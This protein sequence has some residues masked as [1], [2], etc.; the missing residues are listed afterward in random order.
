MSE[1]NTARKQGEKSAS[2]AE[3]FTSRQRVI[4]AIS[5][6]A[7]GSAKDLAVASGVSEKTA[8]LLLTGLRKNA[9]IKKVDG[10]YRLLVPRREVPPVGHDVFRHRALGKSCQLALAAVASWSI[11][12]AGELAEREPLLSVDAAWR[13]LA[14]LRKCGLLCKAGIYRVTGRAA[15]VVAQEHGTLGVGERQR[16]QHQHE[17]ERFREAVENGALQPGF[18]KKRLHVVPQDAPDPVWEGIDATNEQPFKQA[19]SFKPRKKQQ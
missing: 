6:V 13:A 11:H 19:A 14:R 16:K 3:K 17:R 4:D 18:G 5:R 9:I 1:V 8:E 7:I 2:F 12:S 15:D 10:V